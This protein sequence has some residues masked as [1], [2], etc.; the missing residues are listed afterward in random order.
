MMK[1]YAQIDIDGRFAYVSE[2]GIKLL[3]N[4]STVLFDCDGVLIDARE[5]YNHTISKTVSFLSKELLRTKV[6]SKTISD[7]VLYSFR[8][9]GGFN[10]DWDT[11]YA[12]LLFLFTRLSPAILK[13][14]SALY[15]RFKLEGLPSEPYDK[16]DKAKDLLS[17]TKSNVKFLDSI[18]EDL[19]KLA[20]QADSRG[21]ISI[22][23]VLLND[24]FGDAFKGFNMLMSYPGRV[25]V[26]T[27]IT[28][29]EEFF[30]GSD[31]FYRKYGL[32]SRFAKG[33]SGLVSREKTLVKADTLKL[34]AEMFGYHGLGIISGRSKFTARS[35]LKDMLRYFAIELTVFVEDDIAD[36]LEKK[37]DEFAKNMGKPNPYGLLKAEEKA[38]YSGKIIYVGDSREDIIMVERANKITDRFIAVGVY[39]CN[40]N[41]QNV[42]RMFEQNNVPLIIETVNDLPILLMNIKAR[43]KL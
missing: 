4:V 29:F 24:N 14:Y 36:V 42:L 32:R 18:N 13:R 25:G 12:I 7:E 40:N 3:R 33:Y 19:L 30:L 34:L 11:T 1:K 9:S 27:I 10:N 26:S 21:I 39:G 37:G 17:D 22:E 2:D 6:S 28:V 35:T 38:S 43:E 23:E 20:N 5:S 8:K 15:K 16:I 31:F 41:P